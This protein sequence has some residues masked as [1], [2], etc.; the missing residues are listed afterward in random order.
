[1]AVARRKQ[2]AE[3]IEARLSVAVEDSLGLRHAT[4]ERVVAALID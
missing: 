4:D 1:M 3:Q 2:S